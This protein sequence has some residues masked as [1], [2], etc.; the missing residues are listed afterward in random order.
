MRHNERWKDTHT[1]TSHISH[2]TAQSQKINKKILLWN[3]IDV[4]LQDYSSFDT[5]PRTLLRLSTFNLCLALELRLY[6]HIAQPS[7]WIASSYAHCKHATR[8]L[9]CPAKRTK[10]KNVE[11]TISGGLSCDRNKRKREKERE[12]ERETRENNSK[13]QNETKWLIKMAKL[14]PG[15]IVACKVLNKSTVGKHSNAHPR[16]ITVLAG[17]FAFLSFDFLQPER[18]G[19][20]WRWPS[21]PRQNIYVSKINLE[22]TILFHLVLLMIGDLYELNFHLFPFQVCTLAIW[23]CE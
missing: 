2:N 5:R 13:C 11:E 14:C 21:D 18:S 20:E 22:Y 15:I 3:W 12:R 4:N 16:P 17:I 9:L 19:N 23:R 10:C 1:R 6:A 7:P 8:K